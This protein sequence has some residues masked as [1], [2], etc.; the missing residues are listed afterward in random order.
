MATPGHAPVEG[1]DEHQVQHHVQKAAQDEEVQGRFRVADGPQ[2]RGHPV[3]GGEGD[4]Q[5]A[6][7]LHVRDRVVDDV[8]WGAPAG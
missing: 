1:D 7:D 4:G 3:I 6:G 5:P 2:H 8:L